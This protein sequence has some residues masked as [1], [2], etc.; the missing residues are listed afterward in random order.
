MFNFSS[1]LRDLPLYVLSLPILM[2]AFSVHETAHGYVALKLGDPT[3][4]NLGRLT[5]NPI[6]HIDP[7]GFIC[8]MIFHVGW[9][10]PVPIMTR[11][12][13]NPKRDMAITGAAGP[14]SNLSLALIF[15]VLLRVVMLFFTDA[16][17]DDTMRFLVSNSSTVYKGSLSFTFASL[18]V[19]LLE[20]GVII[21]ISLAIFN[22]IPIP[23]FDG[24]RIF[25]AF[26][27]QRLYFA[28]MKY[29]RILMLI[30]L[31]LFVIGFLDG[32]LNWILN[33]LL[34]GMY[35]ICGMS[36]GEPYMTGVIDDF[37]QTEGVLRCMLNYIQQ[38]FVLRF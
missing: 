37:S 22:L 20:L 13:R 36:T 17:Y 34:N 30:V 31:G 7:I 8:M 29:E 2:L 32:P 18:L 15:L 21:N 10:K 4:R 35:F 6:K 24:S 33:N 14:L 1:L 38:L 16:F 3:A 19:Y 9:A 25:Y 28:V 27:P 11:H 12:F 5:L 23:P 26:L